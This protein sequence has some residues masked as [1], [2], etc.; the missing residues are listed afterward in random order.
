M[1]QELE[2]VFVAQGKSVC[3]PIMLESGKVKVE[4]VP[5]EQFQIAPDVFIM[6]AAS[7]ETNRVAI[8]GVWRTKSA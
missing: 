4:K 6:V 1:R 3:F 8:R 7:K 2:V 5:F